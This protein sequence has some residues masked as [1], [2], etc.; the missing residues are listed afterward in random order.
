M[1][2]VNFDPNLWTNKELDRLIELWIEYKSVAESCKEVNKKIKEASEKNDSFKSEIQTS[3]DRCNEIGKKEKI[4]SIESAGEIVQLS[5][6]IKEVRIQ[7]DEIEKEIAKYRD[8]LVD[9]RSKRDNILS[10]INELSD[11]IQNRNSI[12]VKNISGDVSI[13]AIKPFELNVMDYSKTAII[14]LEK[15]A[16]IMFKSFFADNLYKTVRVPE[17]M[18]DRINI[19]NAIKEYN[20]SSKE[21]EENKELD[22]RMKNY[23]AS[24]EA[25]ELADKTEK[26]LS[27]DIGPININFIEGK[28]EEL[29]KE[30]NVMEIDNEAKVEINNDEEKN[31]NI[32]LN[33]SNQEKIVPISIPE[34][35]ATTEEVAVQENIMPNPTSE[36]V[37]N[38]SPEA[39]VPK[40]QEQKEENI[41][42][43]DLNITQEEKKDIPV[44]TPDNVIPL[45]PLSE[46][47]MEENTNVVASVK[48]SEPTEN[49]M[50]LGEKVDP[51][52]N[53]I[54]NAKLERVSNIEANVRKKENRLGVTVRDTGSSLPGY[55][56]GNSLESV[57]KFL[58]LYREAKEEEYV[59]NVSEE[60]ISNIFGSQVEEVKPLKVA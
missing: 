3:T 53:T 40:N 48:N 11:E 6:N 46:N 13:Q 47:R 15:S 21:K 14:A 30:R 29:E 7:E 17:F 42:P 32:N 49:V 20:D 12:E 58:N 54:A 22:E 52:K 45:N 51:K 33:E 18:I 24:I 28:K 19:S 2:F 35:K 55:I 39:V 4:I 1:N 44:A 34:E 60:G 43:L 37:V 36:Q 23:L 26:E 31:E 56:L 10:E 5:K 59:N 50:T 16:A 27:S 41:K 57:Q 8:E 38:A 9:L 25:S